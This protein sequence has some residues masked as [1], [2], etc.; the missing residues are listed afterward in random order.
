[1][2]TSYMG[3]SLVEKSVEKI[4]GFLLIIKISTFFLLI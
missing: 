3:K 2:Y 4:I 1:M